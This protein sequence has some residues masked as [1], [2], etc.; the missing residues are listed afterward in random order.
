MY[1]LSELCRNSHTPE[2][3]KSCE[4]TVRILSVLSI[5][6]LL[7]IIKLLLELR[8]YKKTNVNMTKNLE[9]LVRRLNYLEV[10]QDPDFRNK[11]GDMYL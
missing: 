5:F 11:M 1:V 6:L 9:S 10:Y 2:N 7:C 3:M 4:D 8:Q